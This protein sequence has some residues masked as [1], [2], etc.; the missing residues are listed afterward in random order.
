MKKIVNSVFITLL[1]FCSCNGGSLSPNLN[2]L[3]LVGK[4]NNIKDGTTIYIVDIV[5]NQKLDSVTINNNAF[6]FEE[7]LKNSPKHIYLHT[8]DYSEARMLWVENEEMLFDASKSNF[9][10]AKISGSVTQ[11]EYE[12]FL[13]QIDTIKSDEKQEDMA[14]TFI[15]KYPNSRFSIS[16]LAGYSPNWDKQEVKELFHLMSNENKNSLYGAQVT[17][18]LSLNK[19]HH[20]GDKFTDFEM[21]TPQDIA[22][23]LS[24]NLGKVTLLEFWASWC[25]P[26][27]K[28]NPELVNIYHKYNDKGFE[29]FAVSL[30]FSKD[31]WQEAIEQ[32][33]LIWHHVSDLK[34]RNSTAGLIYGVN[35]IPD[36]Y[37]IDENGNIIG[38][39]LWGEKLAKII[40]E[41]LAH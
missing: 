27:R 35:A 17:K 24:E 21:N 19:K 20:I 6:E 29:I 22:I 34:G 3:N 14:K 4:T 13:R 5:T 2:K 31:S 1:L 8:K 15:Q 9:E 41:E 12:L 30:D 11:M 16:M 28:Q 25:G 10:N 36:N 7:A 26:C 40:E 37:L 18:Y 32:D 23:K 33:K 39:Y 38:Q